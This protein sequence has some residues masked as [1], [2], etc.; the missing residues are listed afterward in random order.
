MA[1]RI[2]GWRTNLSGPVTDPRRIV[3]VGPSNTEILCALGLGRRLVGVDRWSDYPP[4][5]RT[6]PRVGSDLQPQIESVLALRPDLVLTSLHVPGMESNV[7][8]LERAG[9]PY[10]ALG[11]VGLEGVWADM[12]LIGRF[13]GRERRAEALI[14]TTRRRIE[15]V[16]ERFAGVVE[17]PSVHWEWSAHPVIAGRRS[18]VSELIELAGGRNVYLDLDVESQRITPR[19][20][21]ERQPDVV[22]A[23]WCG[24][25]KLPT[26]QRIASRP[27]W[28][29]TPAVRLGRV[30]AW[31]EDLFG[32]P[33]PRLADGV[34]KL[35]E[36]LHPQTASERFENHQRQ[37]GGNGDRLVDVGQ[38]N[39]RIAKRVGQGPR[40][41]AGGHGR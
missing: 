6:L 37:H 36:L 34:E 5:V 33:G 13:V 1:M 21:I 20:A 27:G 25:R 35:A 41:V 22:V 2:E 8:L 14:E 11:G 26:V 32:R 40:R 18:W 30:A 3:S 12:R 15:A 23:C 24:A 39:R 19:E 17:R 31:A 38:A 16:G 4:R 29:Q 9:L 10:L 28:D 7:P